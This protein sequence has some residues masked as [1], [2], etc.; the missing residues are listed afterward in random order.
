MRD[1]EWKNPNALNVGRLIEG[2]CDG[3][4]HRVLVLFNAA[5]EHV[6]FNLAEH[7]RA[8]SWRRLINTAD[9]T[10]D[11]ETVKIDVTKPINLISRSLQILK[12]VDTLDAIQSQ[13]IIIG[14]KHD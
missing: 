10:I 9:E 6:E 2:I 11:H 7:E 13:K 8:Y 3:K 4:Y 5:V 12:S 1:T 14:K